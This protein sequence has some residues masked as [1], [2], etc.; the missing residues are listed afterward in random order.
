MTTMTQLSEVT[1]QIEARAKVLHDAFRAKPPTKDAALVRL[2]AFR[3]FCEWSILHHLPV[4]EAAYVPGNPLSES[5]ARWWVEKLNRLILWL[6]C[7]EVN[8]LHEEIVDLL[9]RPDCWKTT[10]NP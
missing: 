1:R 8:V 6:E 10:L 3:E 7:G 2:K 5:P 9:S 4:T